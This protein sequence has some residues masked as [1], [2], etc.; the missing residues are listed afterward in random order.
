MKQVWVREVVN[1]AAS[2]WVMCSGQADRQTGA[3]SESVIRYSCRLRARRGFEGFARRDGFQVSLGR[4]D[5]YGR[6][7]M[8]QPRARF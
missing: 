1:F 3:T 5:F 8:C 6:V 7:D 2:Q 4:E